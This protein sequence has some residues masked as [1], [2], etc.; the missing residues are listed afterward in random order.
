MSKKIEMVGKQFGRL[1]IIKD[2]GSN[3]NGRATWLCLC[4]CG[5]NVI[6]EGKSLR[7]GN[8]KSCGC[9]NREIVASK[10]KTHGMC[11]TSTYI[12][13][14]GMLTRCTNSNQATYKNYGERGITVCKRWL[15]FELFYNDMGE[16]P[17]GLTIERKNNE[18]GYSPDNCI[19]ADRTTQARNQRIH[20]ANKTGVNGVCWLK[21]DKKFLVQIT[22]N[23][24]AHYIGIYPTLG[25]AKIA[26][27]QAEKKYWDKVA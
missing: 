3:N 27:K 9:L 6:V 4:D 20:T 25:Q 18:L 14:M 12:T 8:T 2:N 26:R 7:N 21:K 11:G 16:R 1:K 22:A 10:A 24:K 13:W 15:N 5:E 23:N 19:W 17:A